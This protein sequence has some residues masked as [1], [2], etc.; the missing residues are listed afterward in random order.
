MIQAT[1]IHLYETFIF[2]PGSREHS[3]GR[4][5]R[6]VFPALMCFF[7]DLPPGGAVFSLKEVCLP[8]L[9]F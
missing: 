3:F 2:D 1:D 5:S 6:E 9:S 8:D 7:N 4:I